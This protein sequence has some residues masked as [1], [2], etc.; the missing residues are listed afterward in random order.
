MP[1][2]TH[3]QSIFTHILNMFSVYCW[4]RLTYEYYFYLRLF[5]IGIGHQNFIVFWKKSLFIFKHYYNI[6]WYFLMLL[7]IHLKFYLN[8]NIVVVIIRVC[9]GCSSF[10]LRTGSQIIVLKDII[11]NWSWIKQKGKGE[12]ESELNRNKWFG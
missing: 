7:Q 8:G 3:N 11:E 1:K 6:E 4:L 2:F 12:R 9:C 5:M 10:F